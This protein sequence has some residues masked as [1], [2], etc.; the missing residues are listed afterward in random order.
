MRMKLVVTSLLLLVTGCGT[1][2][3]P[4]YCVDRGDNA[5]VWLGSHLRST[6]TIDSRLSVAEIDAAT[7]AADSWESA[8]GG[9]VKI[10]FVTSDDIPDNFVVTRARDQDLLPGELA[11]TSGSVVAIGA[12]LEA[13]GYLQQSLVHEFGHYLGLGHEPDLP[14]DI[15]YPCTH[16]GMP[17]VPTPDA[18][19]DL[20]VLYE[21]P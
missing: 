3:P 11:F 15:M 2:C 13:S 18:L 5:D 1:N 21:E 6:L 20:R 9:R 17:S 12:S 8:T 16:E 14:N 4:Q 10:S 19:H 7:A